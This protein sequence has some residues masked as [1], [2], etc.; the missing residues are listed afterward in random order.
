MSNPF[1][2]N[3]ELNPAMRGSVHLGTGFFGDIE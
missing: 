1:P 2:L 3:N